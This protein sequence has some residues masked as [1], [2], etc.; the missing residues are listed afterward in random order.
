MTIDPLPGPPNDLEEHRAK[1]FRRIA[2]RK[3]ALPKDEA[4]AKRFQTLELL[5]R[6]AKTHAE[7]K[8]TQFSL[9]CL[10]VTENDEP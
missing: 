9:D 3:S 6:H 8:Q 2:E 7:L 4:S 1:I 10:E 5:A